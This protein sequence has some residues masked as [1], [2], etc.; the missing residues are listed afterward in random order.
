MEEK[1]LIKSEQYNFKA[2]CTRIIYVSIASIAFGIITYVFNI[3][4]SRR[5]YS[6]FIEHIMYPTMHTGL[7]I[8]LGVVL[9]I[10]FSILKWALSSYELIVTDKRIYGKSAFG[11][12]V[13]LP[14]DSIS[15]IASSWLNGIA[16]ATS[17]GRIEFLLIKNRDDVRNVINKLIIERQEG[18]KPEN[19]SD[20]DDL[21]KYKELLDSGIITQEEF[22]AKK[23]QILGL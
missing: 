5:W 8:D 19:H 15:A 20:H 18:K 9:L 1:V 2:I 4:G 10:V 16:I 17:S 12:Q 14:V 22:N 7:L 3:G 21:L 11:H 23:K 6:S 13:D